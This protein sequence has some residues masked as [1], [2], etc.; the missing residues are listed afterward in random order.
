MHLIAILAAALI[1]Q[2]APGLSEP[3]GGDGVRVDAAVLVSTNASATAE[4]AAVYDL[5]VYTRVESVETVTNDVLTTVTNT[6]VAKVFSPVP[7]EQFDV[8]EVF[9][10]SVTNFFT[11]ATNTVVSLE[12][13][14]GFV[15]TTTNVTMEAT[16]TV[17]ITNT[18]FSL[19]ASD[20]F[21]ETNGVSRCLAPGARLLLTG[22]GLTLFLE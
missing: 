11:L 8:D 17:S 4:V 22:E 20:G 7:T 16:S 19:T 9:G 21:A 10:Q 12:P 2:L 6:V 5:P 13:R 18:L 3:V 15:T 1:L 14:P